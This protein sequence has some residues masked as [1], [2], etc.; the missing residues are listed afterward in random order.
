MT[1]KSAIRTIVLRA[2][3]LIL[4]LCG[5]AL[6]ADVQLPSI[7]SDHMVLQKSAQT[8]VWGTAAP[9]ENIKIALDSLAVS[10]T[11]GPD[12]KWRV[13]LDLQ[14]AGP[15]PFKLI[16][17]GS[18]QLSI[19]DVI[20]G[21]VW[22]ASG[23]SN[24]EFQLSRAEGAPEEI[25]HSANPM[26]RQFIVKE[27]GSVQPL[28]S[29][30][31]KWTVAAPQ[32][33]GGFTAIGYFFGKSIQQKMHIPVGI[34]NSSYGGSALEAWISLAG[35]DKDP[36]LK[37][38][39]ARLCGDAVTYPQRMKDYAVQY[40]AWEAR[41]GRQDHADPDTQKYAAQDISLEG[42]KPVSLP[43]SLANAKLPDSGAVWL[44]RTIQIP[45][46]IANQYLSLTFG[47]LRDLDTV[48]FNGAK[49]GQTTADTTTSFN[50]LVADS[51]ARRY[52][53]AASK[54]K[55][56]ESVVAI[57]LFSPAGNA[58]ID[59]TRGMR[60]GAMDIAGEWLAKPEFEMPA[61][62]AAAKAAYPQRP[63]MPPG[64]RSLATCLFNAMIHPIVPFG[65]KGA[66]WYQG[67]TNAG[68]AF[69]YRKTFPILIQDWRSV[70]K[71]GDFPFYYCQLP[72]HMG[73]E[74]NPSESG[75]AEL[76][77][78][79]SMALRL[80]STGQN[81]LIDIGE[82]GDIHPRNKRDAGD[83]LAL[84][85]LAKTYGQSVVYS[86]PVYDSMAVEG[87]NVR[88]RFRSVD[89]GLIA[90][91]LPTTYQP[92]STD[93]RTVPLVHNSPNSELEGF[94]ICGSDRKWV[95]AN[96]KIDGDSVVVSS[97]AVQTPVAVR[98]AWANNP[99]CNLYNGAELPAGPFRTDDFPGVTVAKHYGM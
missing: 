2:T 19:A 36:A 70:W 83:R 72:N 86:G 20:V 67:E 59:S 5:P 23:Q 15:G 55:P 4:V 37:A 22:L 13:N 73:K 63:L 94:A 53:I 87:N 41:Y 1:P 76:R 95:W 47:N 82:E 57:R 52:D 74:I 90:R 96:A 6:W 78:A 34:I 92:K 9:G 12:G 84:I 3:V 69:E 51:N 48:Y 40:H 71:E 32:T 42:W 44:R 56:G 68:T 11:A 89:G 17:A 66:I 45:P 93:P 43:G 49:V 25:A 35:F 14:K 85:A 97:P 18:N 7:F 21:D 8:P 30:E 54:V 65:I 58:G 29:C 24:M 10:A 81:V 91:K 28:D 60:A 77:E 99:T 31:G 75:W 39:T 80:P 62:D 16:V 27:T 88:V 46:G 61:L 79:Q 33:S 64:V 38:T 98:Y 26:L 50:V